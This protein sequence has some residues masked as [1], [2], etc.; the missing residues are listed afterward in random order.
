M[1]VYLI[2]KTSWE[3]RWQKVVI[4]LGRSL[5]CTLLLAFKIL[6]TNVPF[7]TKMFLLLGLLSSF[8]V[9]FNILRFA[10]NGFKLVMLAVLFLAPFKYQYIVFETVPY[11][12]LQLDPFTYQHSLIPSRVVS[13]DDTCF[14]LLYYSSQASIKGQETFDGASVFYNGKDAENWTKYMT[15]NGDLCS[16]KNWNN[17]VDFVT[18]EMGSD[19]FK[20]LRFNNVE[21]IRSQSPM[22]Y[23]GLT[24]VKDQEIRYPTNFSIFH[25]TISKATWYLYRLQDPLSRVM[26]IPKRA[27]T[28]DQGRSFPDK[29]LFDTM[30]KIP[31]KNVKLDA[32]VPSRL[33]WQGDFEGQDLLISTNYHKNWQVSVDN[34]LLKSAVSEGPFSMIQVTPVKGWHNYCLRYVDNTIYYMFLCAAVGFLLLF[35]Y[36]FRSFE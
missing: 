33:T 22:A 14:E 11:G 9:L 2:E 24:L 6:P 26:S 18:G 4:G 10:T 20:W 7:L 35:V 5:A 28:D 31:L 13:A 27:L 25:K 3:M 29:I 36:V 12:G 34:R 15:Q 16:I 1:I 30:D 19:A 32:Y 8:Y 21:F 17:R 23:P